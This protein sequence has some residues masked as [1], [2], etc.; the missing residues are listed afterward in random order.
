MAEV[1]EGVVEEAEE[2]VVDDETEEIGDNVMKEEVEV[3]TPLAVTVS[4]TVLAGNVIVAGAA[5]TIE[6]EQDGATA[7]AQG[8]LKGG[9]PRPLP[10]L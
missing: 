4:V 5:V 10:P 2:V 3:P 1:L 8:Q 7:V 9:Q 6:G